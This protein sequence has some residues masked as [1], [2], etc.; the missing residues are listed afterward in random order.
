MEIEKDNEVI[1]SIAEKLAVL[2]NQTAKNVENN[3]QKYKNQYDS[4]MAE[5]EFEIK[6][7]SSGLEYLKEEN[8]TFSAIEQEGY[9]R[10]LKQMVDKFRSWE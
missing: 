4:V 2:V 5:L 8:L 7:A 3:E 1:M 9:L 10:C 6:Q